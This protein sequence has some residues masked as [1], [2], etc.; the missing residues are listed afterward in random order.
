MPPER[1][2]V[3]QGL[4]TSW[5]GVRKVTELPVHCY[6]YGADQDGYEQSED[7]LYLNVIR[8]ANTK[9]TADLPV[10]V[11]IHGGGLK[12]GGASDLRY[13]L[14][15]IVEQSVA[16]G[17][18]IIGIGLNYRVSALGF[19]IGKEVL[20]EGATNLGFRDQRLALHW[21]Q[22]NV[23][24]FGGNPDKV[25][26]FGE[27][28]GAES[29]AAQVFAYNGRDD[30]LFRG[31]IGQSGFGAPLGRHRGGYN[32]T[33]A[34]QDTYDR[35]VGKVP[36]CS[37]LVG[38]D[39][40]LPCLRKAPFSEIDD[41]I[42]AINTGLEWAPVL[43]GDFIADYTTNQL[44]NGN[45]P[46]VPLLI[47]ANTDEGTSFGRNRRSDG[48]NVNT[49]EDMRDAI[50]VMIPPQVEDTAGQ[51]VEELTDELMEL[52]P[53]DQRVGIPSLE[54]WS[55]IIKPNDS[56]AEVHGAQY[57]RSCALFG[58][59]LMQYQRRRANKY[60]AKNGIP[61]YAYRFN[62]K[63][64]GQPEFAGVTHFQEVAFVLY[65]IIGNGYTRKPFGG[66]G[67][68]PDDAKSM[69]KTIST[70]WINFFNTL[71][72]NGNTG[73][74]LFS[75]KE[76]PIYDLSD[77]PDGEGIVFNINGSEIEVDD[78]RS[79]GMDWMAEHAL[80]VFGN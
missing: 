69:A 41:A 80:D 63:P 67:S 5:D 66:E 29:V 45:F 74:E 15:F 37:G 79:D 76:W 17:T 58:D 13:N 61:N 7:C 38:S 55:H 11:W 31:A 53:N 43:D 62:I 49:D 34:M 16:L 68:Y 30:G 47:G 6:G 48:G 24:A 32:A 18:P 75:G 26:I 8:P 78:W 39:K 10:A 52:Y 40:S 50:G 20:K 73:K 3:A 23:K 70:A 4:N 56:Y 59:F 44:E 21:V 72:P 9:A 57:R 71:D 1:F 12:M 65:N 25:T 46:K 2:S 77:G 27:S 42:W 54:S 60:W 33:E 28:S 14:S 51:T 64:N 19:I 36:S 22:E 35:F